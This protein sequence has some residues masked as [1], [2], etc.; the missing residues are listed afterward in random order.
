MRRRHSRAF[1]G[2][3]STVWEALDVLGAEELR[4]LVRELLPWLDDRIR[5]RLANEMIDR[6]ARR[7]SGWAPTRP[8]DEAVSGILSFAEAAKRVG[9]ADASEVDGYLRQGSNAFL[10]KHYRTACRIFRAFLVP[11][12]E[13]EIDLGQDEM[14]DEVLGVDV[15]NCA[16]QYV[17]ATY[18]VTVPAERAKAVYQA[19]DEVRGVGLFWQPLQDMERVAVEPLPDFDDF[20]QWWRASLEESAGQQRRGDW[21]SEEN[22]WLREVVQRVE[23]AAGL[24]SLARATKRADDLR[25][26][27]RAL[28][29]ARDWDAAL[30]AYEE[31][32]ESVTRDAYSRGEFLDGAAL[33]AQEQGR[34][35]LPNW[36]ERAWREAPSFVRLCRWLGSVGSKPAVEK[37][38]IQ[39]LAACP[40]KAH[41]QRA[42]LQVLLGNLEAAARLLAAAPG[43]GWSESEHPGSLLFPVFEALLEGKATS[44]VDTVDPGSIDGTGATAVEFMP[45][46]RDEPRLVTPGLDEIMELAGVAGPPD[47]GE[48][49]AIVVA[50]RKAAEKRVAGVTANKRRRHYGHAAALVLA[51]AARD[52]TRETATWVAGIRDAYRR[53]PAFQAELAGQGNRS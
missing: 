21:D 20:L 12:G 9:Y 46:S 38:A 30:V 29:D 23:G 50:M 17:V 13:G 26:W 36:L 34:T 40:R 51:C 1:G 5:A 14:L 45:F 41:R 52:S 18:M 8:R 49:Q 31:A 44:L 47:S 19:I 16:A 7:G 28:V 53:F 43:L 3:S 10:G 33:A 42:F 4:E 25:A 22:R 39:A 37:S 32:A 6:A 35:D 11:L 15:G 2:E 27:C 48:R 24:A